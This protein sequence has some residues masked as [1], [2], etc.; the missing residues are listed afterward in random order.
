MTILP[1]L[2]KTPDNIELAQVSAAAAEKNG[3]QDADLPKILSSKVAMEV[4][5]LLIF[6]RPAIAH[7]SSPEHTVFKG[8]FH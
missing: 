2:T 5:A 6:S 3:I 1:N 7:R 4:L 8:R